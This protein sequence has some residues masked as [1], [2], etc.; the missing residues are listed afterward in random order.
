MGILGLVY[1]Y[2]ERSDRTLENVMCST[3]PRYPATSP[4]EYVVICIASINKYARIQNEYF[5]L[6]I[7]AFQSVENAKEIVLENK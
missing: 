4:G 7:T 1:E 2:T 6:F 3:I 5:S